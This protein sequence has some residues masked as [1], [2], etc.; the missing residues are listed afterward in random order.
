MPDQPPIPH[1][2]TYAAPQGIRVAT[3]EE[4]KP[5][6]KLV[7]KMLA[8]RMPKLARPGKISKQ[9]ITIKHKEKVKYW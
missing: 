5:M 3:H 9:T 4:Q 7:G 8:A 2:P 6:I 1:L